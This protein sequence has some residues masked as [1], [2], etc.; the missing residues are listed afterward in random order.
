[1]SRPLEER[2]WEKVDRGAD[3]ECWTWRASTV[4]KGYGKINIGG[5]IVYAHRVSWFL[6]TGEWPD[7]YV[8]HHCDNPP[9][10]NPAHLWLGTLAE[11]NA[12]MTAKGRARRTGWRQAVVAHVANARA[13]THCKRGHPFDEGNTRYTK[14]GRRVC[15]TCR[16]A[17]DREQKRRQSAARRAALN[18]ARAGLPPGSH[19]PTIVSAPVGSVD[20]LQR[21]YSFDMAGGVSL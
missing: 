11:N 19:A 7:L 20:T 10:V 2:F 3:E 18:A 15:V 21:T 9:C 6:A 4:P 17:A 12:D 8:L 13:R 1:M 14:D 5:R 16:R